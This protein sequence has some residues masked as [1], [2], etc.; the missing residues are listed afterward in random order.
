MKQARQIRTVLSLLNRQ[1]QMI[2]A[3]QLYWPSA[4]F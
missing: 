2:K 4:E 3:S 1:Y